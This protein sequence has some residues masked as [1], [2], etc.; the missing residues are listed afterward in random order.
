MP[1]CTVLYC[2]AM[3]C[4]CCL[5]YEYCALL[6]AV[7]PTALCYTILLTT[8]RAAVLYSTVLYPSS[9]TRPVLFYYSKS[10]LY[11]YIITMYKC[12]F[13]KDICTLFS[14]ARGSFLALSDAEHAGDFSLTVTCL[15]GILC[16]EDYVDLD[17]WM[18]M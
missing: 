3:S 2:S 16:G 11:Y 15:L 6:C 18:H 12:V 17:D 7:V 1:C 8:L 10:R 9:C 4:P 14:G 5:R 13:F